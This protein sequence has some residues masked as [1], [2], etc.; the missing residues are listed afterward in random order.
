MNIDSGVHGGKQQFDVILGCEAQSRKECGRFRDRL[1]G[2]IRVQKE[3]AVR[4][5]GKSQPVFPQWVHPR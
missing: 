2:E 1:T 4:P 5:L 3:Q